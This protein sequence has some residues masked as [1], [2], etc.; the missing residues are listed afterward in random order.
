MRKNKYVFEELIDRKN[1]LKEE[2]YC[3]NVG[4]FEYG[5]SKNV[6]KILYGSDVYRYDIYKYRDDD[7][8]IINLGGGDPIKYK[9]YKYVKKD[10]NK[11]LK[12]NKLNYYPH[13][14]GNENVK[15]KLKEYLES[16]NISNVLDEELII[17]SSTTHAYSLIL[18][19][20]V[21]KH[22]VVIIP[23]PTYGLFVY[24]PEKLG[25]TVE[26]IELKEENH[27]KINL[28]ELRNKIIEINNDLKKKYRYLNYVP[29]VI[30]I[31]NQ[32]PNNPLG[33][34]LGK[35]EIKY[36]YNFVKL[37]D[38]FKV[39]IIDDLVYRDLVYDNKNIALP[40]AT[41][42]KYKDNIVSLFGISKSY[43]LAGIR[44]GFAL[45]NKYIIQDM[46]DNLFLQMDS[47]SIISQIAL[48]SILNN[49]KK[50]VEYR[51][52]YLDKIKIKYLENLDIIKYFICGSNCVSKKSKKK[53]EK[54]LTKEEIKI[55]KD[56]LKLISIYNDL[57]PE[58]GFFVLLD[59]TKI[60]GKQINN[61]EINNDVDL[62]IELYK[63]EK[64]KF[65]PG[66]SFGWNN[67]SQIIGRITFSK[68]WNILFDDM[69][70][71]TKI[72]MDVK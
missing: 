12:Q 17:T 32:N 68:P 47:V 37:C 55:Y 36:L 7:E 51:N 62:I 13:T 30:A 8:R 1:Y 64:I 39:L 33:V 40:L 19:S 9:T 46:R 6:D 16:I 24:E 22:D 14:T 70:T 43:S 23:I 59:F 3:P 15:I 10:I 69:K 57:I 11:F 20:V 56:G 4:V 63:K 58:S 67:N 49:D 54:R 35:S 34:S 44:V 60:K 72:L 27:F 18:K 5:K 21:R 53:I 42:T 71:L 31:Y 2:N 45:G 29:R 66:S 26:F 25:G 28:N 52:K 65:L 41:F 48:A 61:K 38:E 50:R